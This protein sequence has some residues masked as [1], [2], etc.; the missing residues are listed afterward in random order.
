M[1]SGKC[2]KPDES[3]I[4][5]V[6]K[7]A[8]EKLDA[9]HV[10]DRSFDSLSFNLLVAGELEIALL[11]SGPEKIVR[12]NIA[13]TICYHKQY[14]KDEDLRSGYDYIMKKVE[15]GMMSWEDDLADELHKHY[16][17]RA[18]ITLRERLS[19]NGYKK[20]DK[21]DKGSEGPRVTEV[22]FKDLEKTR[23]AFCM[24]FNH[25]NCAH[26]SS[27]EDNFGGRKCIKWHICR[28]C[29]RFGE[30]RSHPENDGK[31]PHK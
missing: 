10:Q 1:V 16:E 27:H 13:K 25:G 22:V 7:Y 29:R 19:E 28:R 5:Q 20:T 4:K 23:P 3:D 14:L 17:Y 2:T 21:I 15:Q 11:Q 31:C 6:V 9:K 12:V 26:E 30:L 18:N 24:E 8:H